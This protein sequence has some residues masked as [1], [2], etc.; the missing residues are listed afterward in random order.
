MKKWTCKTTHDGY[1]LLRGY[2][3]GVIEDS[4]LTDAD[5]LKLISNYLPYVHQG[6]EAAQN[7]TFGNGE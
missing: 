2:I 3:G 4:D 5:K 6:I 7:D 1:Y